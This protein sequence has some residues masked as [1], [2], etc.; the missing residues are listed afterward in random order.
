MRAEGARADEPLLALHNNTVSGD[1]LTSVSSFAGPTARKAAEMA[2]RFLLAVES[3]TR[4]L[5]VAAAEEAAVGVVVGDGCERMLTA[6]MTLDVFRRGVP[7]GTL[8]SDSDVPR[9][10]FSGEIDR[11]A[12]TC[13]VGLLCHV[14]PFRWGVRLLGR[15]LLATRM[16]L[17]SQITLCMC[18]R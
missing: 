10:T 12:R 14:L 3:I 9:S 1:C 13:R 2:G 17:L 18:A 16:P 5:P 11:P 4:G 15:S 8:V 6:L 7:S